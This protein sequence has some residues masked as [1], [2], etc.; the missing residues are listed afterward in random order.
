MQLWI[1]SHFVM[2]S[3]AVG[4]GV[5]VGTATC[6]LT[7]HG[8]YH[9][10]CSLEFW[11]LVLVGSYK[12][13]EVTYCFNFRAPVLLLLFRYE[14]HFCQET[15]ATCSTAVAILTTLADDLHLSCCSNAASEGHKLCPLQCGLK[16]GEQGGQGILYASNYLGNGQLDTTARVILKHAGIAINVYCFS[17][18]KTG[19]SLLPIRERPADTHQQ[20]LHRDT[21]MANLQE[22]R[23]CSHPLS[24][25]S[26]M[27]YL[28]VLQLRQVWEGPGFDTSDVIVGQWQYLQCG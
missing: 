14:P 9:S 11:C 18:Y 13:F 8:S 21:L 5:P 3:S 12:C 28:Q 1:F 17:C 23:L 7:A 19:L 10:F 25:G 6:S 4:T 26:D 2:Q 16:F 24:Y 22:T 15:H 20:R 27:L